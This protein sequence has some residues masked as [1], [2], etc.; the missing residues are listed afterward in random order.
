MDEQ[1]GYRQVGG[2]VWLIYVKQDVGNKVATWGRSAPARRRISL[3][4]YRSRGSGE[5]ADVLKGI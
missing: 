3:N 1:Q 5:F 4:P 2:R